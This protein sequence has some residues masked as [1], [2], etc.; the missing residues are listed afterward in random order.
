MSKQLPRYLGVTEEQTTHIVVGIEP[1]SLCGETI[2]SVGYT[3]PIPYTR[4]VLEFDIE[5]TDCEH[6]WMR[7]RHQINPEP[8]TRCDECETTVTEP[9]IRLVDAH[10]STQ[11]AYICR[12]CYRILYESE[13]TSIDTPYDEARRSISVPDAERTLD[14]EKLEVED[15][16]DMP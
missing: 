13:Q 8:T 6:I 7:I 3:K 9:S 1:E 14:S 10:V 5:C 15:S 2:S 11:S 4:D 12:N 16:V